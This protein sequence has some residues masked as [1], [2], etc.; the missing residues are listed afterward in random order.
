M[1]QRRATR[2]GVAP[3]SPAMR[4]TVSTAASCWRRQAMRSCDHLTASAAVLGRSCRTQG[5][6]D[7]FKHLD[8]VE[9]A[10][11]APHPH[12]ISGSRGGTR[13]RACRRYG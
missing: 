1:S 8:R 12:G 5:L 6:R 2:V 11:A 4:T 7:P 10:Q 13:L 3:V 9:Q